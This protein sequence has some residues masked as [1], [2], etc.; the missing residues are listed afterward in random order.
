MSWSLL[1]DNHPVYDNYSD[2]QVSVMEIPS[3]ETS[4]CSIEIKENNNQSTA[5]FRCDNS[6]FGSSRK[7]SWISASSLEFLELIKSTLLN[8]TQ[9][10]VNEVKKD[11]VTK[12][13]FIKAGILKELN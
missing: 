5:I 1:A 11:Q 13:V 8:Y 10:S 2:V 4:E 3:G 6:R 12:Q 7:I 9:I